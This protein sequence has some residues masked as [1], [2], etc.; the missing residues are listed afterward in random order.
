MYLF[1]FSDSGAS[2]SKVVRAAH[3]PMGGWAEDSQVAPRH[4]DPVPEESS[5]DEMPP[6]VHKV[7][8]FTEVC[9]FA[10]NY[11]CGCR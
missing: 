1:Y 7:N 6:H 9:K 2:G 4:H 8:T 11:F 10:L 5:E 3:S